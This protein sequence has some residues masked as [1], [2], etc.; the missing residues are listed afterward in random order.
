MPASVTG[1]A[2]TVDHSV[3]GGEEAPAQL[4]SPEK[5]DVSGSTIVQ[6]E[7]ERSY[8]QQ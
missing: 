8:L 1:G 7:P 6:Q 5:R 3:A 4:E 2:N